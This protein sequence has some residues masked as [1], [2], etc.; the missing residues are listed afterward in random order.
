MTRVSNV[1]RI[2]SIIITVFVI[3]EG[4]PVWGRQLSPLTPGF[5]RAAPGRALRGHRAR[6]VVHPDVCINLPLSLTSRRKFSCK[7]YGQFEIYLQKLEYPF[8]N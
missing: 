5:R 7:I 2:I 4:T 6:R 3:C 1:A 8:K